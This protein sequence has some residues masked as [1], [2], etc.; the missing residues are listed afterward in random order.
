MTA[1]VSLVGAGP[2]DPELLT[3]RAAKRL[4]E[5]EVVVFDALVSDDVLALAPASAERST[6]A[7]GPGR[8]SPRTSSTCCWCAWPAKAS[9]WCG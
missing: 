8:A 2:G 3:V 9:G 4:A 1:L 7:S 5:A 6:W